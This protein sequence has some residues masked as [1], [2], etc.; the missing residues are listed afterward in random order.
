ME[1]FF[2]TG[3]SPSIKDFTLALISLF[4]FRSKMPTVGGGD[5]TEEAAFKHHE[6][7]PAV[8]ANP[9]RATVPGG[10]TTV[11]QSSRFEQPSPPLC[12]PNRDTWRTV[13]DRN[14]S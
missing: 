11:A 6:V 14:M 2:A 5:K 10:T 3:Y 12:H 9:T 13:D 1:P 4:V 8:R 7:G